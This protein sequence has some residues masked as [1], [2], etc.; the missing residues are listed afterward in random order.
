M[1]VLTFEVTAIEPLLMARVEGDPNSAVSFPYIPGSVIRGA[2]I[3]RYRP[4]APKDLAGDD[5]CRRLFFE[6]TTCYLNAYPLRNG[7]RAL[8]TPLALFQERKAN[9]NQVL[10]FSVQ[11]N[12]DVNQPV[13]L[14]DELCWLAGGQITSYKDRDYRHIAVHTA[15]ERVK[16]RATE[17]EGAVFRY[18]AIAPGA[19]FQGVILADEA[20]T[21]ILKE[22]LASGEMWLGKSRT[23][24][25]G[26]AAINNIQEPPT[27]SE[28]G[29]IPSSPPQRF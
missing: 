21:P 25:Y 20:D 28:T 5:A 12:D 19:R 4:R 8:P 26:R 13:N 6:G 23:G 15:R 1:K 18:Q 29:T 7:A 11:I 24:G 17:D 2:L 9:N 27:W 16:G 14:K 10:D 22:L 3:D